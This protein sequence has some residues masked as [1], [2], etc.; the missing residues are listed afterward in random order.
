MTCKIITD[1][2]KV[3]T[4]F[5]EDIP[6]MT[7]HKNLIQKYYTNFVKKCNG[8]VLLS[9]LGLG[10]M[11]DMLSIKPNVTNITVIEISQEIIDTV[12][13]KSDKVK[14]VCGDIYKFIQSTKDSFDCAYFDIWQDMSKETWTEMKNLKAMCSEKIK[15]TECWNEKEMNRKYQ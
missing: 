10:I 12:E 14:V 1:R 6:I 3:K 8:S 13:V 4:L 2:Y 9:G 11:A 5:L 7:S 15:Y